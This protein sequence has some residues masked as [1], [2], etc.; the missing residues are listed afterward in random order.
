[1]VPLVCEVAPTATLAPV[2]AN[3]ATRAV[4]FVPY[5]TVAAI[6]VPLIVAVTS[7]VTP[8]ALLSA[9]VNLKDVSSCA[10]FSAIVTVTVNTFIVPS[11]AVT[12][13][14]TGA[15]KSFTLMPLDWL[16]PATVTLVPVDWNVARSAVTFVP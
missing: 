3:V 14:S 7:A 4:T 13:Y 9:E 12:V 2:V 1:M 15:V 10:V 8:A 11:P 5:G 6:E 16:V